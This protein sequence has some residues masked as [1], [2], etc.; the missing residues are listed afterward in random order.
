M[1]VF[2]TTRAFRSGTG[3]I[4]HV[5]VANGPGPTDNL[6]GLNT[7]STGLA[8][9]IMKPGDAS[10]T[11]FSG[12][13]LETITTIGTYQAPSSGKIRF[14]EID[15]TN[16]EGWYEIHL[17]AAQ[18]PSGAGA[19]VMRVGITDTPNL[20]GVHVWNEVHL[21]AFDD[22]GTAGAN[23]QLMF[24]G[25]GYAGGTTKLDVNVVS[26]TGSL[27]AGGFLKTTVQGFDVNLKDG[28]LNLLNVNIEGIHGADASDQA[29][30]G[31]MKCDVVRVDGID[32]AN[33][34][35]GR[36]DVNAER[37]NN[38]AAPTMV[39]VYDSVVDYVEDGTNGQ[40][41]VRWRKN[42]VPVAVTGT[43]QINL[44]SRTDDSDVVSATNMTQVGSSGTWKYTRLSAL[45]SGGIPL[46]VVLTA[47]IDGATR[48]HEVFISRDA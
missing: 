48:T 41:T 33:A 46:K 43:P 1:A 30:D 5:F 31:I 11:V 35:A 38:V 47:T 2:S 28:T 14:K 40:F 18:V 24:N 25:T 26:F 22:A 19:S 27:L 6:A 21:S 23:K 37:V 15:A 10:P 16:M 34:A 9:V 32:N 42:G 45:L 39:D 3:F 4:L 29:P 13:N 20:G 8:I 17:A 44:K 7:A 36:L 12:S